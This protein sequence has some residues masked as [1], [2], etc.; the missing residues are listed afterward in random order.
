MPRS[1]TA[2]ID[3]GTGVAIGAAG[4]RSRYYL[5]D[6]FNKVPMLSASY[7]LNGNFDDEEAEAAIEANHN[8]ETGGTGTEVVAASTGG[9]V[10]LTTGANDEDQAYLLPNTSSLLDVAW[11]TVQWSTD[12]RPSLQW[13]FSTG[14][15]VS[16]CTICAGFFLAHDAPYAVSGDA[17]RIWFEYVAGDGTNGN[18]VVAITSI[19]GTDREQPLTIEL[20]V[21]TAY[22][23]KIDVTEDRT[24]DMFFGK[25][26]DPGSANHV[27]TDALTTA[28]TAL[29]PTIMV[30]SGAAATKTITAHHCAI[31]RDL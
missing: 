15:N 25:V 2:A 22:W 26:S 21:S 4:P 13:V 9:G 23:C 16:D 14:A 31:G 28:I 8:W 7:N 10:S 11:D 19:G 18:K 29:K 5:E 3:V 24:A 12:K 1:A 27:R 30:E 20:E 6:N 17:D